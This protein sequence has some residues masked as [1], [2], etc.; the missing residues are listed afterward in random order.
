MPSNIEATLNAIIGFSEI[1]AHR[2]LGPLNQ[3]YAD[4]AEDIRISGEHLLAIINDIL[5]FARIDTENITLSSEA[6]DLGGVVNA[7]ITLTTAQALKPGCPI[8]KD[9]VKNKLAD[10]EIR[11]R[12]DEHRF[13]QVFGQIIANAIKFSPQ[14][15]PI[16]ISGNPV[17]D[18]F[19][20]Q[21]RDQGIGMSAEHV[22]RVL[23]P[24]YQVD[25]DLNRRFEG[26]G[27]GLPIADRLVRL[28]GGTLAIESEPGSG[29]RVTVTLP[30]AS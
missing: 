12:G 4:Y 28:H 22:S 23:K 26:V 18:G 17:R 10:A 24:F 5:E 3:T 14:G 15:R 25:A 13:R 27:L 9:C 6:V 19:A 7:A 2:H 1:I 30:V 21:V 8:S 20:V 29:T 11:L 16:E